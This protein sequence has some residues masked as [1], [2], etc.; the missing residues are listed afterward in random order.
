VLLERKAGELK[1]E[2]NKPKLPSAQN[3]KT[4]DTDISSDQL[5]ARLRAASRSWNSGRAIIGFFGSKIF[6]EKRANEP[7]TA[8]CLA[9]NFNCE[10]NWVINNHK[11]SSKKRKANEVYLACVF[12][13]RPCS[14]AVNLGRAGRL[15]EK[16]TLLFKKLVQKGRQENMRQEYI[17]PTSMLMIRQKKKV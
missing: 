12:R 9:Y 15:S 17:F 13:G 8:N 4:Q 3:Q 7:L 1:W 11:I 6:R 2:S 5:A 14:A 10:K 16:P